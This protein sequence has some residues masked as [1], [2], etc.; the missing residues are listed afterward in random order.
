MDEVQGEKR[1]FELPKVVSSGN[2]I[3][4]EF[5]QKRVVAY[6]R[7]STKQEEQLKRY[8]TQESRLEAC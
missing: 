8:D 7:V 3:K 5:V 2:S 6:C 1:V 4:K